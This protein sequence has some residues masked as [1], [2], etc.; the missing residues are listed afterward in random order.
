M[1]RPSNTDERRRQIALG[2]RRTMAR[3][4]YDGASVADVARAARLTPGLVHYHFK[5]KLEILLAVL[6]GLVEEHEARL[7]RAVA[8]AGADAAAALAAFLDVHLAVGPRA[9]PEALACWNIL[10]TEAL[11]QPRVGRAFARSLRGLRDRLL[12]IIAAGLAEGSFRTSEPEAAAAA[13][14]ATIE[15]YFVVAATARDLIP[16]ASAAR[17]ARAMATGLLSP[18]RPFPEVDR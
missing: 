2:L 14:L 15:G 7:D 6:D 5:D 9:D 17:A 10:G 1:P 4:G 3:K 12:A 18:R 11:R 8:D 16:R 13:L